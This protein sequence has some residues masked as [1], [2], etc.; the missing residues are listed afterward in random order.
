MGSNI[1]SP[2]LPTILEAY[3]K[4]YK[5]INNKKH[6]DVMKMTNFDYIAKCAVHCTGSL[7]HY[8]TS[9]KTSKTGIVSFSAGCNLVITATTQYALHITSCK[10]VHSY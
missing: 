5:F 6:T 7:Y 2:S 9:V 8:C 3:A 10:I 4:K 1:Y